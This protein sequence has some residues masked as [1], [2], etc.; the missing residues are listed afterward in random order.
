MVTGSTRVV[1]VIGDPVRHSLS[2]AIHNAAFAALGLDWVYVAFPVPAGQG[3]EA[4]AA[5]RTLG[6]AGL[7]VT[8]PHKAPVAAACD[9]LTDDARALGA[10]NTVVIGDDGRA[11]GASTDGEGFLAALAEDG[12]AVGPGTTVLVVGAGGAAKAVVLALARAG[13][14]VT[15][16]ARRAEAAAE[17]AAL[18]PGVGTCPLGSPGALAPAMAKAELVV[19]AT[20]AGM[21]GAAVPFEPG[22]LRPGQTVADL[23]YHPAETPLLAAAR[24]L[25]ARTHNGLGMLI[26]QAAAAFTLWTGRPAPLEAMREG[27]LRAIAAR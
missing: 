9:D 18:A 6:L 26:H 5:A 7:S 24:T 19:N 14:E 1:G 4:V 12:I 20:P 3:G 13:A 22:L 16:A 11:L 17:A 27:A 25:G 10:V 8:M 21:D 15:V 23:I 2:P